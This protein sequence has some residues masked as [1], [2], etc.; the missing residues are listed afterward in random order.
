MED[1]E[2]EVENQDIVQRKNKLK[3]F[4]FGWVKDKYD[5]LFLA[6]LIF[7]III[8]IYFFWVT[9]TQPVWWDEA[10]YL[11]FAKIIGKG[12]SIDYVLSTTRPFF[13]QML[14]AL[15]FKMGLGEISLR[16]TELI[17]SIL[18]IWAAYLIGKTIFNKKV[19]LISAFLLAVFWQHLF[20]TYR[21]MTEIPSVT[22]FLFAVYFFWSGY[23]KKQD[24]MLIWF[25]VFFGL[26]LLTRAAVL[27]TVLVF[28]IFLIIVDKHKFLKNKYLWFSVIIALLILSTFLGYIAVEKGGN[29]VEQFLK[30]GSGRFAMDKAMKFQGIL[31]YSSF[32]PEYLGK[33]LLIPF[34]IGLAVLIF[35]LAI[36]IDLV[37]KNKSSK[38]RKYLFI[39]LW[40]LIPFLYHAIVGDHM[41]PRYLL[42]AFPAFF[43]VLSIGLLEIGKWIKQGTKSKIAV[44]VV[45]LIILLFG[46]YYQLDQSGK[47]IKQ[48]ASSY[49]EVKQAA[50]WLKDNTLESETILTRSYYQN[51]Y[52]SERKTYNFVSETEE[53]FD[54]EIREIKPDYFI[55][56]I[57]EPY[58]EWI[59]SYPDRN[60]EFLV[61]IQAYQ[62]GEQ[63]VLIIYKLNYAGNY[64]SEE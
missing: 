51:I 8:R 24:K 58:P 19:G 49:A 39:F 18:A 9:K 23:V 26:A 5:L 57:F 42:I 38:M 52:Y 41:E 59:Y 54:K 46:A 62:Q 45:I 3:K 31:V 16:L 34:V 60:K 7:A 29:P 48:K 17:F 37:L 4:F 50:L 25:G 12:L 47:M 40:F 1:S 11:S 14:W 13:L 2:K 61:P 33:V 20:F 35:N 22:F 56:S 6:I 43:I 15:C 63:A 30:V 44:I 64:T 53:D 10:D 28:L 32:F 55:L 21:L 36:N 27:M